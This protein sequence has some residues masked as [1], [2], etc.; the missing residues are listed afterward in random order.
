MNPNKRKTLAFGILILF[1]I[2]TILPNISAN[3]IKNTKQEPS[4][5]SQSGNYEYI[6]ITTRYF[7]NSYFQQLLDHKSQYLTTKMVFV[8][9]IVNDPDYSV[10]GR[11]GDAT[12]A[13]GGNHWVPNG[14][15]V[16]SNFERFDDTQARIRN[17]LRYAKDSW[18]TKYV[19]IGGDVEVV[20]VRKLRI[21]ETMWYGGITSIWTYA[22]IRS[23]LY[24]AALDGTWNNDFDEFFGEAFPYS[25]AEEADFVA[26]LYI[27]R[28][29]VSTKN[30]V[31]TFV[32]KVISFEN[33][34]KP[35]DLLFHQAGL[36]KANNPDSSVVPEI[37]Y[38]HVPDHYTVYKL[39]QIHTLVTKSKYVNNWKNPD[40]LIVLH[41][42]SG[43]NFFYYLDRQTIDT[44]SYTHLRAHET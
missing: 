44:V 10:H 30:D 19:L 29:P 14:K 25:V 24:Y 35:E 8:E 27:G 40:K 12:S 37:C 31:V 3:T 16:T 7:Q 11:Y 39:Y 5:L 17:F 28:A 2:G 15:E 9:D 20:P 43:E 26:E 1:I 22:N 18:N 21:N 6:I 13:S 34:E 32:N 36:N 33:S 41:V 42:G 38:T 4:L 23:D